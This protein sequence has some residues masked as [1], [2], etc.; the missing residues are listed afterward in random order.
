[1]KKT[2]V[3]KQAH[4][5]NEFLLAIKVRS[6]NPWLPAAEVA[7]ELD[8]DERRTR[9]RLLKMEQAGLLESKV[10]GNVRYFRKKE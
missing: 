4:T 6:L 8:E 2:E 10:H 3:K 7:E 9:E 1:M 5:D